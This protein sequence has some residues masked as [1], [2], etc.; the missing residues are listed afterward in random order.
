MSAGS[1]TTTTVSHPELKAI[2]VWGGIAEMRYQ[3]SDEK[4][5][6]FAQERLWRQKRFRISKDELEK[7]FETP[8]DWSKKEGQLT[9]IP[10]LPEDSE[11]RVG[12]DERGRIGVLPKHPDSP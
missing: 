4:F 8:V 12:L 9:S 7:E 3:G 10:A 11:W 6:Y 5:H 1:C 2:D